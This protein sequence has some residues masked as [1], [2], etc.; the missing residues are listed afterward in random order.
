VVYTSPTGQVTQF[1]KGTTSG[2]KAGS[3]VGG[4]VM[5]AF[6]PSMAVKV[7]FMYVELN[8]NSHTF[9]PPSGGGYFFS[10][11]GTAHFSLIRA[12]F[13]WHF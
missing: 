12:G 9:Y 3:E 1:A 10:N 2:T 4:G 13:Q 5:Y 11:N 8:S 7:E 6:P